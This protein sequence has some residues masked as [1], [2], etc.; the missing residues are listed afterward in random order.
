MDDDEL[1]GPIDGNRGDRASHPPESR[2]SQDV[3]GG[4]DRWNLEEFH[5]SWPGKFAR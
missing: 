1:I 4:L 3:H 2:Q 5:R